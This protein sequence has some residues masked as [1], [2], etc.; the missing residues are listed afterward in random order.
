MAYVLPNEQRAKQGCIKSS[1]LFMM[2]YK[3]AL[4][5]F[6][7]ISQMI[8]QQRRVFKTNGSALSDFRKTEMNK[9]F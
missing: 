6:S 3:G 4:A 9:C 1:V 2:G 8:F 5:S 7:N